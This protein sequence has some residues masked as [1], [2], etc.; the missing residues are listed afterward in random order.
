MVKKTHQPEVDVCDAG[1]LCGAVPIVRN[2]VLVG[3]VSFR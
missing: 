3:L 2:G 1:L